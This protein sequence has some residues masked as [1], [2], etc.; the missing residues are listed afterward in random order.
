MHLNLFLFTFLH[1]NDPEEIKKKGTTRATLSSRDW[2][3]SSALENK[4]VFLYTIMDEYNQ[5]DAFQIRNMADFISR[6][7]Q[8][9]EDLQ[10]K[11]TK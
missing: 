6:K 4:A 8:E 5:S 11:A 2:E 9:L 10:A 7:L 3:Q 1:L